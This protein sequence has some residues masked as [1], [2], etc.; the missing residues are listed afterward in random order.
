MIRLKRYSWLLLITLAVSVV[1]Y[2]LFNIVRVSFHYEKHETLVRVYPSLLKRAIEENASDDEIRKILF[3]IPNHHRFLN[4]MS[5][6][7]SGRCYLDL[8]VRKK[9][10][11]IVKILIENGANPD[12]PVSDSQFWKS[13]NKTWAC[14]F[15]LFSAI[16]NLDK[17][18]I[19]LLLVNGAS[20]TI[21]TPDGVSAIEISVRNNLPLDIKE[22]LCEHSPYAKILMKHYEKQYKVPQNFRYTID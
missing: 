16:E 2:I 7:L 10:L 12:G 15:P 13:S 1:F 14:S 21:C 4:E 17:D 5:N 11:N 8:A 19:K 9:N 22:I 18:M 6:E 20:S 3:M